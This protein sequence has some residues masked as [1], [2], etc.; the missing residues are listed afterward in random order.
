MARR[1]VK[2]LLSVAL[3]A[4]TASAQFPDIPPGHY[5]ESAVTRLV[6]LGVMT[7]FPDGLFRG[8]AELDRYQLAVILT[9][10]WDSW[11]T[12]QLNEVW[13][14]ITGLELALARMQQQQA[15]MRQ[16]LEQLAR[17]EARLAR[18]EEALVLLDTRTRDVGE[19][20]RT[21]GG[22][23]V[24]LGRLQEE[25][26]TL[27]SRLGEERQVRGRDQ[28]S[29]TNRLEALTA[30]LNR[31]QRQLE[32]GRTAQGRRV[33]ALERRLNQ[34]QRDLE[35]M[36]AIQQE[37]L[38]LLTDP[39]RESMWTGAFSVAGGVRGEA[40]SY[41][42][43]ADLETPFGEAEVALSPF[44]IEAQAAANVTPGVALLGRYHTALGGEQGVA[45]VRFDLAQA[46]SFSVLGGYDLGIAAGA[47]LA[48]D[49]LAEN[50]ALPGLTVLAGG[51]SGR[52]D[53]DGSFSRLLLQGFAG[54]RFGTDALGVQP[55]FLYRRETGLSNSQLFAGE[56]RV[57]LEQPAWELSLAGR[58]GL[59]QDLTGGP[60]LG[61][62]EA[63]LTFSMES[64]AFVRA[65][66][67][68]GLPDASDLP[69]FADGSPFL[70]DQLVVG[71]EAGLEVPLESLR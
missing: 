60:D 7:G 6:D 19:T 20:S 24:E 18:S 14:E 35:T 5:A 45:G 51:L 17:L 70:S 52:D 23:N 46:L 8:Q 11:S 27:R 34:R 16:E 28:V 58:Y 53:L 63:D 13:S 43:G 30:R 21:V 50:A 15:L 38:D 37:T 67:S 12:A 61:V 33:Q 71:L 2:L 54:V 10:M 9:R 25:I 57:L 47:V 68:G 4:P 31:V 1:V 32:E 41:R 3:L 48:H 64:G 39:E 36:L 42:V 26:T 62:P 69:A 22:I 66:L 29:V 40:A 59:I 65:E 55:G 44:G 49:G 56:V